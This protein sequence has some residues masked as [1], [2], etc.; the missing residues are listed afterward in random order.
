MKKVIRGNVTEEMATDNVEQPK[1][2]WEVDMQ[3][4]SAILLPSTVIMATM[5]LKS[6][7]KAHFV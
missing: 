7:R 6:F 3:C 5:T 4:G 2:I 1:K